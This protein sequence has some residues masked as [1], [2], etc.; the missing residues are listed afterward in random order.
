MP[1]LLLL[2][3]VPQYGIVMEKSTAVN[4]PDFYYPLTPIDGLILPHF[5]LSLTL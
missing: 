5:G 2:P 4:H 3:E 1:L